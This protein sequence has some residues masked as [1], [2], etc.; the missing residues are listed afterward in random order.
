MVSINIDYSQFR[1][2]YLPD[3]ASFILQNHL[4]EFVTVSI[5]F[6]QES[7]VPLLRA[8]SRFSEE[9]LVNLGTDS[10]SVT[11]ARLAKNQIASHIEENAKKWIDDTLGIVRRDEILGEDITLIFYVR[12]RTFAYFLDMYTKNVVLQKL[13]I[14]EV[15]TYTTQEE[16]ICYNIYFDIQRARLKEAQEQVAYHKELLLEAQE[17]SGHG[18]FLIDFQDPSR[19]IYTPEYQRI[20]EMEARTPIEEFLKCV[21]PEDRPALERI[22]YT[23]YRNGGKFEAEYRYRKSG[24]EKRIWSK[25]MVLSQDG[26]PTI[27]RGVVREVQPD[28]RVS[29][30]K[31]ERLSA[32]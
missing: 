28:G 11:L 9:E 32:L 17:F 19:C 5:R 10:N 31:S 22:M 6:A 26:K 20:F 15:D 21:N 27:I 23:A 12:R 8:L 2:Q 13:I 29:E 25:G 14:G 3:Y 1:F 18:S 4:R 30:S 24:P 7:N 16:L